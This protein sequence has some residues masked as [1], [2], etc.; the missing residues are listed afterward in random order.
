[1]IVTQNKIKAIK[2]ITVQTTD[3]RSNRRLNYD[4][5]DYCDYC[6][7]YTKQNQGNHKNQKNHSSDT[8]NDYYD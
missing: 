4:Y 6:D 7:C 2:K 1:M 8:L 5:C 3:E